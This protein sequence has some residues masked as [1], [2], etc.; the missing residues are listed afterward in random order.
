MPKPPTPQDRY[1]YGVAE[2]YLAAAD[3]RFLPQLAELWDPAQLVP[4]AEAWKR[5]GRPWARAQ[6]I[7]YL[8]RPFDHAGHEPIVKRLFKQAEAARDDELMAHFTAAFDR[9]VRRRRRRSGGIEKLIAPPCD[10]LRTVH[11]EVGPPRRLTLGHHLFSYHTRHYLRRRAWRY[12]RRTGYGLDGRSAHHDYAASVARFL[13]LYTD[14]DVATGENL[15]DCWSAVHAL[16]GGGEVLAFGPSYV[17]VAPGHRLAELSA[18]PAHAALWE[19]A[20]A[21]APLLSLAADARCGPVRAWAVELLRRHHLNQLTNVSA[22]LLL[23]MLDHADPAVQQFAADLLDRSTTLGEL[24][25][26]D[27]LRL[28]QTRNVGALD[29]IA[30]ALRRHVRAEQIDVPRLVD[31]ATAQPV[32]VARLG[33][34]Y[35]RTRQVDDVDQLARLADAASPAVGGEVA[36]FALGQLAKAYDVD[37][38]S[39]F[40]DSA[41]AS[42]RSAAFAFLRSDSGTAGHADAALYSRLLETPYEDVRLALVADLQNRRTLPGQ[43]AGALSSL[44]AGVLLGIHRGGRA[45]LTALRQVSDAVV[46]GPLGRGGAAAGAGRRHPLG[47]RGRGPGR[48]GRRRHRRRAVAAADGRRAAT[49]AGAAVRGASRVDFRR[50]KRSQPQMGRR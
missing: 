32:P 47:P 45:K 36:A 4:I 33:L 43:S 12:Y 25:L 30:R 8:S 34:D 38:V 27:W 49:A 3:D 14:A 22:A 17:R 37:P 15:I 23:R 28:L 5:D 35:L 44:W 21:A 48:P 46:R 6:V 29:G 31:L 1:P 42:V 10:K 11:A 20:N 7:A 13:V 16:F 18:T 19:R 24:T 41:N 39:R 9:T 40:F 26:D 50:E 2:Q